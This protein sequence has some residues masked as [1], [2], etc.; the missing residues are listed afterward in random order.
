MEK[1]ASTIFLVSTNTPCHPRNT[2]RNRLR[3]YKRP[4]GTMTHNLDSLMIFIHPPLSIIGYLCIM[5][6]LPLLYREVIQKKKNRW[7]HATLTGAWL[8][9]FAGLITGM[10][11][12]W[13]AW[14]SYWNWDL[15]ES[16]T[17][18]LFITVCMAL[19]L[20]EKTK[21]VSLCF[22]ILSGI[23]VIINIFVTLGNT[24]LHSYGI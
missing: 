5:G 18:V 8:F 2:N 10:I 12:A 13:S 3:L 11:W 6:A 15:K 20:Y 1:N 4:R 9:N 17:L 16:V 24:S 7:T 14:G 23:I 22:L 19:I 21:K